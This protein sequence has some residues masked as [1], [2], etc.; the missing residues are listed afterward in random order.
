MEKR[1]VLRILLTNDDGIEAAGIEAL[2]RVLSP[3]HTVVVA[4]PAFEQ[5][6]MSHAIT[7]KR[8]IRLDRCRPLEERYGVAAYRIEGTPADCV[9][10]YLEAI[11]SDIYPEY[12]ISGINH[13]ANLG[14]DVLYSGT[15]NAAMEAYLHGITATAISI[16]MES[17]I[18][19]DTAAKL[20]SEN[21]F[22]L[23][24]EEGKANFY[25]VNFPKRFI[26]G[27]PQFIFTQLGRRDYINAF[28]KME[29]ED[30]KECYFLGGE[31]LDEGNSEATDIVATGRGYISVTPL[32]TDLTDY[33]YLEKLLR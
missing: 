14:T 33:L 20:M 12:V 26:D 1:D 4:A 18:S 10:L 2:V 16:D 32:Q 15:A 6:G 19:Y 8:C 23:F 3:H 17:E 5:S 30:G 25:N 13:G 7:V 9:K 11:S 29:G 27:E 22:T 31:I 21:L 24:Y 28:Q